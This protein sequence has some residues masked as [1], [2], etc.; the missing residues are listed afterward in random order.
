MMREYARRIISAAFLSAVAIAAVCLTASSPASASDHCEE[1][2]LPR[3]LFPE[4]DFAFF[5]RQY[6]DWNGGVVRSEETGMEIRPIE[7]HE[8]LLEG[9][10]NTGLLITCSYDGV[11][12]KH[13]IAF[14][15]GKIESSRIFRG[16]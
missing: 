12:T 9:R 3:N 10:V 5:P 14:V 7:S 1:T 2:T 13:R 8:R 6:H 4:R 15:N 11:T 16:D